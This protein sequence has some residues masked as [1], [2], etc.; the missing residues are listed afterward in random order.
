MRKV[1]VIKLPKRQY[2]VCVVQHSETGKKASF[3]FDQYGITGFIHGNWF[4]NM[5][6]S[7]YNYT[8]WDNIKK[9]EIAIMEKIAKI[10]KW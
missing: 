3:A 9:A 8:D 4:I 2:G 7:S 6:D 10:Y 5:F 1:K